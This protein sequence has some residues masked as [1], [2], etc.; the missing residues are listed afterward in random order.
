MAEKSCVQKDGESF[1][2]WSHTRAYIRQPASPLLGLSNIDSLSYRDLS[3]CIFKSS[4]SITNLRVS[5]FLQH[6]TRISYIADSVKCFAV[7]ILNMY[8]YT[9]TKFYY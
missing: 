7:N 6:W 8:H 3:S 2:M 1:R 4:Q 5:I 9:R